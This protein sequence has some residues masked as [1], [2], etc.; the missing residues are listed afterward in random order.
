M[1]NLNE[2]LKIQKQS[3]IIQK[4]NQDTVQIIWQYLEEIRYY[5]NVKIHDENHKYLDK[6]FDTDNN[7]PKA[8][9][10]NKILKNPHMDE[11]NKLSN[12]EAYTNK[13][14]CQKI[15]SICENHN[16]AKNLEAHFF[17]II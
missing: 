14:D 4:S 2:I 5:L 12:L 7:N 10:T 15:M 17:Q 3:K 11:I 13:I 1:Q 6:N 9:F 8:R 16:K